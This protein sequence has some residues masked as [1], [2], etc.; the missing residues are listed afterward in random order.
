MHALLL[1]P[2][3]PSLLS[4]QL[5][6]FIAD[7]GIA[8]IRDSLLEAEERARSKS[9]ARA[10]VQ[11]KMG[12]IDIDYQVL[13]DAFFK[14]QTKPK[15]TSHGELYYEGK[16]FETNARDYKPGVLSAS[17]LAALD[18]PNSRAPPPW[19]T[20]MQRYGPPPSYPSLR[21]PGL[22]APIPKD[23]SFGYH[24]GGWGKPPVDEYGRPIYGDVFGAYA[25]IDEGEEIVDKATRWGA[26][27]Q[28]A[29]E[30]EEDDDDDDDDDAGAEASESQ[31]AV[32]GE[33]NA[34]EGEEEEAGLIAETSSVPAAIDPVTFGDGALDL[35]K[36]D[37]ADPHNKDPSPPRLFTVLSEKGAPTAGGAG[38]GELFG[39]SKTYD[40]GQAGAAAASGEGDDGNAT[41]SKQGG[42]KSK[43]KR[44]N[45]GE[46]AAKKFKDSFKF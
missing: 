43:R 40:L 14:F 3:F 36:R 45:E 15:F 2:P 20:N 21:I 26:L 27:V 25:G 44:V 46:Q 24:P 32:G 23:A 6:E 5:P 37:A 8:K 35:R 38:G 10:R 33:D 22:N 7:T 29:E 19:L 12:K 34:E 28:D 30:E 4:P 42:D 13:H 9:R 39:S 1:T 16:E 17:L 41:V 31:G 18:L 11:P